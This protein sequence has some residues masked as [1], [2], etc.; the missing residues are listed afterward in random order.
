[1]PVVTLQCSNRSHPVQGEPLSPS[2]LHQ[3]PVTSTAITAVAIDPNITI[4]NPSTVVVCRSCCFHPLIRAPPPGPEEPSTVPK[5]Q[6][7]IPTPATGAAS[8]HRS[9]SSSRGS[10]MSTK[11]SNRP[12]GAHTPTELDP[13]HLCKGPC[14]GRR[15]W[16]RRSMVLP[17]CRVHCDLDQ[18]FVPMNTDG[19][20]TLQFP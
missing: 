19:R 20:Q 15:Q 11:Q 18:R 13:S 2:I 10:T 12:M 5:E 1:M 14:A 4:I 7:V 9:Q 8:T 6:V 17:W 16:Q 3:R